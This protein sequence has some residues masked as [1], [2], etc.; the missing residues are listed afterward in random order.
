[1]TAHTP[2]EKEMAT[3]RKQ[4]MVE[5]AEINKQQAKQEHAGEKEQARAGGT[6]PGH[7]GEVPITSGVA[8][9]SPIGTATGTGRTAAAHNPLSGGTQGG[10]QG[11]GGGYT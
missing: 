1:M 4:Q 7:T 8:Q 9:T 5:Q 2:A 11:T 10:G 3:E 6:V